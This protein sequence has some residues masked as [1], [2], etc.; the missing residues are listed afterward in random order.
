MKKLFVIFAFILP[1]FSENLYDKSSFTE[2]LVCKLLKKCKENNFRLFD[3]CDRYEYDEMG[4]IINYE[5][6]YEWRGTLQI[7]DD[8]AFSLSEDNGNYFN[9]DFFCSIDQA[10]DYARRNFIIFP[11]FDQCEASDN[12]CIVPG[13]VKT[14]YKF[15]T[16][17]GNC[18][19][20]FK[21]IVYGVLPSVFHFKTQ[22]IDDSSSSTSKIHTLEQD[23]NKIYLVRHKMATL[24]DYGREEATVYSLYAQFKQENVNGRVVY[25]KISEECNCIWDNEFFDFDENESEKVAK[26]AEMVFNQILKDIPKPDLKEPNSITAQEYGYCGCFKRYVGKIVGKI[27]GVT[28]MVY[29]SVKNFSNRLFIKKA[30]IR[31]ENILNELCQK[32]QANECVK[33]NIST[34]S[35]S[36]VHKIFNYF[37]SCIG[38]FLKLIIEEIVS[39]L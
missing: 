32:D 25:K 31:P 3:G 17:V 9:S 29:D 12:E 13:Y 6:I 37:L 4:K 15:C 27:S 30:N 7:N 21:N 36:F 11:D 5:R 38:G 10:M 26:N 23:N 24:N 1:I 20:K 8:D 33:E 28:G 22:S 16:G 19:A 18:V 34:Q 2:D 14:F 39:L 35:K